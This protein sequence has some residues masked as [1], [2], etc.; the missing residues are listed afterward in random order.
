MIDLHTGL[1][2]DGKTLYT[3]SVV[4]ARR[5]KENRQVYYHNIK[6]LTLDWQVLPDPTKWYDLPPGSIIV[7]DECQ[8]VFPPRPNG[9]PIPEHEARLETH[10]HSGF[11]IYLITQDP[12][13]LPS[14]LRKLV[15]THKH[16]MRKFGSRWVTVHQFK[17][18]R[19]TVS[20]S[21]KDSIESQ[22]VDDKSMYGKYKTAEVIT[23]RL[24]VPAKLWFA[25]LLPVLI[26]SLGYYFYSKRIKPAEST[27]RPPPSSTTKTLPENQ[28]LPTAVKKTYD[29]A[30]FTPR[31]EG[32]PHTAPRYDDLT[33]PVRVPVVSGCIWNNSKNI[34]YCYTQQGTRM[35]MS[36]QFITQYIERGMFEDFDRGVGLG[37]A[38]DS[39]DNKSDSTPITRPL[40]DNPR[41]GAAL[42][43]G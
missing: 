9:A 33:A 14:H 2:G 35:T 12:T 36:K 40:K 31:I 16:L 39:R 32:L 6:D 22:W 13:F 23:Q 43:G 26:G 21:R 25:L 5:L 37:V 10:R 27:L 41:G 11:D 30:S 42:A 34:G 29:L 7:I 1:P 38:V 28:A 20:K 18:S 17:G 3:L 8:Q 19:D 15:D 24:R 4:E